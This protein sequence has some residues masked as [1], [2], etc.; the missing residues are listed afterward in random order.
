MP[1][2]KVLEPEVRRRTHKQKTLKRCGCHSHLS[3]L[4]HC[5]EIL[6]LKNEIGAHELMSTIYKHTVQTGRKS[7]A[8]MEKM[9]KRQVLNGTGSCSL[10]SACRW[11]SCNGC[12]SGDLRQQQH[13]AALWATKQPSLGTA[14]LAPHGDG[15]KKDGLNKACLTLTW[16]VSCRQQGASLLSGKKNKRKTKT[17]SLK[18]AFWKFRIMQNSEYHPQ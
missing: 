4:S 1:L 7:P 10:N 17:A 6:S 3:P 18:V 16:L 9:Q 11:L 12:S 5:G 13:S 14:L 8:L 2:T 15:S